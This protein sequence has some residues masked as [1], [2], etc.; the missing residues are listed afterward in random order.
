MRI[1]GLSLLTSA[2][3]SFIERPFRTLLTMLGIVIGVAAVF[4]SVSLGEAS[5]EEIRKN[6]DSIE[7][8]SMTVLR[9][10]GSRSS[11]NRPW[12]PFKDSDVD[13]IRALPNVYAA[14]GD[15]NSQYTVVSEVSD[16]NVDVRGVDTSYLKARE[17]EMDRG[18]EI[19]QTDIDSNAT[20]AV[21]GPSTARSLFPNQDPI[22]QRIKIQNVPFRVIGLTKPKGGTNWRGQ[23]GD[24]YVLIP[25][26][27]GRAR[28][29]GDSRLVRKQV[30]S[31]VV[32]GETPAVM[33]DIKKDVH[34]VM[35][36]SRGLSVDQPPDYQIFD[37]TANRQSS[38]R[39]QE[40][41]NFMF[42]L[43]AGIALVVGGVG[44]INI[45]LATVTERTREIGLRK[46]LGAR[47]SDI[48]SLFLFEAILIALIS[49][50]IGLSVGYYAAEFLAEMQDL[51]VKYT[52]T[53]ALIAF[54]ASFI[55]GIISGF[56]P[57]FN[58]SRL[59]PVEALRNE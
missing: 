31:I 7:A 33:Q 13:E 43:F 22:G 58:A 24:D 59:D 3:S 9:T 51:K 34:L 27:T 21:I 55:T 50:L 30:R 17:F 32:V 5:R 2:F 52:M 44:V 4:I 14:T 23:D 18:F 20:V 56:I 57:A 15:L 48:L 42:S 12:T 54:G 35:R 26:S 41:I 39:V 6:L 25:R 47:R 19:T 29:F 10:F 16:W 37:F 45:M 28:L 8:R 46:S 40:T 49:G 53:G 38:A 36:R 11:R 1:P